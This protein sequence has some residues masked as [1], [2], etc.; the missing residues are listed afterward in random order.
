VG[1]SYDVT[2]RI[3]RVIT[4][5]GSVKARNVA[6]GSR[7][8]LCQIDG[9]R[10]LTLEGEARVREDAAAVVEAVRRYADRYRPPRPNPERVAIEIAVDRILGG[11]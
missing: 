6:A 4:R 9:R 2:T 1:F 10:W 3:A 7:A 11:A 5:R 8:V